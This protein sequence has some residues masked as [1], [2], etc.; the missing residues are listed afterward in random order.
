MLNKQI[1]VKMLKKGLFVSIIAI[2]LSSCAD[3]STSPDGMAQ[4]EVISS[5]KTGTINQSAGKTVFLEH[6]LDSLKVTNF[7]MLISSI[8]MHG[9]L[10]SEDKNESFKTGPYVLRGDSTGHYYYL[11]E[12]SIPEGSYD[13]IKFEIHKFPESER[14]KFVDDTLFGEFATSDKYTI[15]I[16]G[17]YYE[18]GVETPFAFKSNKTENL[19]L[20]FEPNL[21]LDDDGDNHVDLEIIPELLFVKNGTIIKPTEDN[22]KDIEDNIHSALKALKKNF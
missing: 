2:L 9:Q 13:K 18:D 7:R 10:D 17:F 1:G 11:S 12:H 20:K 15:L 14:V 3:D 5:L 22:W 21:E 16:D 6:G 8:K 19:S 4:V